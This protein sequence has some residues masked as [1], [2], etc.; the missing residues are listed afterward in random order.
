MTV[1]VCVTGVKGGAT[2]GH[3]R[4]AAFLL[5]EPRRVKDK[6]KISIE[7]RID[8]SAGIWCFINSEDVGGSA[9]CKAF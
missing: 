9:R 8:L 4:Q 5:P 1:R 3:W 6:T 2:P 7:L